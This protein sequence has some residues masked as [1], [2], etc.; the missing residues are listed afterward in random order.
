MKTVH[1]NPGLGSENGN[2]C[3]THHYS[4]QIPDQRSAEII[5]TI[6]N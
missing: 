3:H 4:V 6:F 2:T 5:L 1:D